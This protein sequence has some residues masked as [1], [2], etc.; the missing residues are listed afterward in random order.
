MTD[1]REAV[2]V[3]QE[4]GVVAFPT[5][6]LWALAC[7][8][9]DDEAV[10]RVFELKRRPEGVPLAVGCHSWRAAQ[11][12]I[13]ATPLAD[14]L[15]EAFLPGPLSLV[16][17]RRGEA[18]AHVAPTLDTLSIR[19][20]DHEIALRI[21]DACGPLVMTSA[22]LHGSPDAITA[23]DV[24]AVFDVP[25][26]GDRVPGTASTVVDATGQ[27]PVILRQGM[28]SETM[29]QQALAQSR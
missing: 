6:T 29:I 2:R 16:L 1:I 8:A 19:V 12:W 24:R 11:A 13:L 25:V 28:L 7:S 4:G 5:E 9:M 3:L 21:L 15:A 27:E 17:K 10:Q 18:L 20:P 26:V 23:N 22:N 14:R